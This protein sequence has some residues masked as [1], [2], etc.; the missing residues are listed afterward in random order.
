MTK[1]IGKNIRSK[2]GR[3][4]DID[5]RALQTDQA[6]FL[7]IRVELQIDKPLR[8]GGYIKNDEGERIWVDF[9]YERLPTFYFRCGILG[10]D[11]KHCQAS[12]LEFSSERQYS[13]WLKAVGA[14]RVGGE[15]EKLKEQ[16]IADK[17]SS[18]PMVLNG[19]DGG[20]CMTGSS[21][22]SPEL[23]VGRGAGEE[24]GSEMMEEVVPLNTGKSSVMFSHGEQGKQVNWKE[25]V[26]EASVSEL[27]GTARERLNE[28]RNTLV[29]NEWY[30]TVVGQQ[31]ASKAF[32]PDLYENREMNPLRINA[33]KG[34]SGRIK[35]GPVLCEDGK[36]SPLRMTEN[37]GLS[38][39]IRGESALK[40]ADGFEPVRQE[41]EKES[42]SV[43]RTQPF[44]PNCMIKQGVRG[45]MK[46]IAREKGKFQEVVQS[47][48][49]QEVCKK[50]KVHDEMFSISDNKV[51]K[52]L[53]EGEQGGSIN[54]FAETAMTVEQHHLAQ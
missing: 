52:H 40:E 33:A 37:V 6:K 44:C 27:E 10:H 51:Q 17:G 34:L 20:E 41:E 30:G 4:L 16:P 22:C 23:V 21:R 1:E 29:R 5:K 12:S 54:L 35:D 14:L 42:S 31:V 9:R 15:K 13:E 28:T 32:G 7:R 53:C 2:I 3:V 38:G 45:R 25:R 8:R 43:E 24:Y 11:E 19:R 49:A 46:K 47:E 39:E 48:Q 36:I 18:V 26:P 50:R